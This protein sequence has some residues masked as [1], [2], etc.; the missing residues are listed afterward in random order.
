M[1]KNNTARGRF[2]NVDRLLK[3]SKAGHNSG[4]QETHPG[5]L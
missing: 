3:E 5:G 1:R 4:P 2:E